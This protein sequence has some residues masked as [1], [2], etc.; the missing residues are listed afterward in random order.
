MMK[1]CKKLIIFINPPYAEATT[2]TQATNAGKNKDGVASGNATYERYK[3]S[4]GK[5]SMKFRTIFL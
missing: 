1:K 3:D 5:A 4:I 2:A